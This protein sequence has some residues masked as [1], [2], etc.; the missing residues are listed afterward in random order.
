MGLALLIAVLLD[1]LGLRLVMV[2]G[3]GNDNEVWNSFEKVL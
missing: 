2:P 1:G 3:A